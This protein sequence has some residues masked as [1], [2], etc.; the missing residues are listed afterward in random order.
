MQGRPCDKRLH[1]ETPSAGPSGSKYPHGVPYPLR[2]VSVLGIVPADRHAV[3]S[4]T[5][6]RSI[7]RHSRADKPEPGV[8][9]VI[10]RSRK[11]RRRIRQP[12][13]FDYFPSE[14]RPSER[15]VFPAKAYRPIIRSGSSSERVQK[16]NGRWPENRTAAHTEQNPAPAPVR[17]IRRT[18]RKDHAPAEPSLAAG[19]TSMILVLTKQ[20]G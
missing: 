12:D 9:T 18:E 10:Q 2:Q 17:A 19:P 13:R 1:P 14:I 6:D 7:R 5:G 15:G 4:Q 16:G 11:I 3:I 20:S 8:S